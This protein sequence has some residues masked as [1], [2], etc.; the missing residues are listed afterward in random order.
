MA[1]GKHGGKRRRIWRWERGLIRAIPLYPGEINALDQLASIPEM[2]VTPAQSAEG[3]A[4][5][6]T[7]D[8]FFATSF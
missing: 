8:A 1:V 2:D 5:V 6:K 4:D 3:I 7:L